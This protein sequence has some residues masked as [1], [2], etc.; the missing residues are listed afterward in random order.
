[1]TTLLTSYW[2]RHSNSIF[3]SFTVSHYAYFHLLYLCEGRVQRNSRWKHSPLIYLWNIVCLP[4]ACT[5]GG[6]IF[7]FLRNIISIVIINEKQQLEFGNSLMV[8]IIQRADSPQCGSALGNKQSGHRTRALCAALFFRVCT[9]F[10][11]FSSKWTGFSSISVHR[12]KLGLGP[13]SRWYTLSDSP[14]LNG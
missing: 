6:I 1:M 11:S 4:R 3:T 12:L 8:S 2:D 9:Q 7:L 13:S 5:E 10:Q 14:P